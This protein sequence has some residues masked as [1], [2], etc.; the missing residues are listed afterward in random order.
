[1]EIPQKDETIKIVRVLLLMCSAIRAPAVGE[2][3]DEF[4]THAED[5]LSGA[6]A[7]LSDDEQQLTTF[8]FDLCT[9]EWFASKSGARSTIGS[10][11][12][13]RLKSFTQTFDSQNTAKRRFKLAN[14]INY[15]RISDMQSQLAIYDCV[16]MF[17]SFMWN[18]LWGNRSDANTD[19]LAFER[20]Y[21]ST[22]PNLRI[23][24][25]ERGRGITYDFSGSLMGMS[26]SK[27]KDDVNQRRR[28]LIY[29]VFELQTFHIKGRIIPFFTKR[30]SSVGWQRKRLRFEIEEDFIQSPGEKP[31]KVCRF[32]SDVNKLHEE[33][34]PM[35]MI[36]NQEPEPGNSL[37]P[38]FG[39]ITR[40]GLARCRNLRI[41]SGP[42]EAF[43]H[44]IAGKR[45][46]VL[47]EVHQNKAWAP[48]HH[49]NQEVHTW[50]AE[51]AAFAPQCLD[52][53][54][55]IFHYPGGFRPRQ[56]HTTESNEIIEWDRNTIPSLR[57]GNFESGLPAIR[58]TF[59]PCKS[60]SRLNCFGKSVRYHNVDMRNLFLMNAMNNLMDPS[61][62]VDDDD[63]GLLSLDV[64]L[65]KNNFHGGRTYS[66]LCA[67]N[68]DMFFMKLGN[69]TQFDEDEF[70]ELSEGICRYIATGDP[71]YR[72]HSIRMTEMMI[73]AAMKIDP[74]M[75][76]YKLSSDQHDEYLR[77]TIMTKMQKTRNKVDTSTANHILEH[78]LNTTFDAF[79]MSKIDLGLSIF[80]H[81]FVVDYYCMLRMFMKFD[82]NKM[83]LG[84][85]GCRKDENRNTSNVI[86]YAG[87]KH[88]RN[89]SNTLK[90]MG[91]LCKIE[92]L[93]TE[94]YD[95]NHMWVTFDPPFDFW[96]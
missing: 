41:L 90:L 72:M 16:L 71:S 95:K 24:S 61:N 38:D 60:T 26:A 19:D 84:P 39:S 83:A 51:M 85:E 3:I 1:M 42:H 55:E 47:G 12:D 78:L 63:P 56:P 28:K 57:E 27:T 45:I 43:F 74:S 73:D 67:R 96:E 2:R 89:I 53:M 10:Y 59:E 70:R 91:S 87:H 79:L 65:V 48:E 36:E 68:S 50:L 6:A 54:V 64:Q 4:F 46:L 69:L 17:Q 34:V 66:Q 44:R 20:F 13:E 86:F 94:P 93:A 76:R 49:D 9:T 33:N 29:T 58:K 88:A 35:Q 15:A 37:S 11:G 22:K 77:R 32:A 30:L 31:T 40:L 5:I 18:E 21:N 52:I 14:L 62:V 25:Y 7:L 23:L 92:I 80:V 8:E 75:D 82:A 81:N